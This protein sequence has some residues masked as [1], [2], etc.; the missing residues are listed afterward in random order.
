V[1]CID[2]VRKLQG[3]EDFQRPSR[4]SKRKSAASKHPVVILV[5]NQDGSHCLIMTSTSIHHIPLP[6]LHIPMLKGLV[7]L[8]QVAV[9]RLPISRSIIELL[10]EERGMRPFKEG[11]LGSSDDIF[12]HVLR[13]LWDE[14]AKPVIKSLDI[15]VCY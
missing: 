14:L 15:E 9:H 12:R 3:F 8:V 5:A 7:H 2:D 1:K 13:T 10:G 6:N 4:L 11:K